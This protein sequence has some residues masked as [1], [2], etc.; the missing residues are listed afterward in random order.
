MYEN[1]FDVNITSLWNKRYWNEGGRY[2]GAHWYRA[3][4]EEKKEWKSTKA[5]QQIEIVTSIAQVTFEINIS[6]TLKG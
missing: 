2:F 1:K 4:D 5:G 6:Q 3:S